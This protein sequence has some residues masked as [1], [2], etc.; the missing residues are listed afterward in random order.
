MKEAVPNFYHKF[1]CIAGECRHN[2]CI[3]WEID[4]DAETMQLYQEMKTPLGE[5]I[6]SNVEG[7]PPHFVL[8][9]G[10]RCPLLN[11][12]GLCDIICACG[13]DALCEIC[14]LHPRFRNFYSDFAETGLGLCCEEAA[15]IILAEC[16]PFSVVMPEDVVL[17]EEEELFFARR[18]AIFSVL[19]DREKT[20][21]ARFSVLAEGFG[22]SFSF[23]LSELLPVYLGL[24]RLDESWTDM[25]CDLDGYEFSGSVFESEAFSLSFEQLSVY[26]IFRHLTDAMWDGDYSDRV[27][28]ALLSCF[29]IGALW[30]YQK[31]KR[32]EL[33]LSDM[34]EIVRMYSAEVE[35]SEENVETLLFTES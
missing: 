15:R 26:F 14:S 19:Q 8:A 20:M 24:E 30:S 32:G 9:E 35:Y 1:K 7:E 33:S 34:A 29:I 3:G 21:K 2:C 12:E 11:A 4:I 22:F 28:F 16:E 25:L 13:E 23:S 31:E 6:L 18:D 27:R 17:S 5:R 10:E